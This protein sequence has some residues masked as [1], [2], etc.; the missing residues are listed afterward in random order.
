MFK[1]HSKRIVFY[2][3]LLLFFIC[4][5]PSISKAAPERRPVPHEQEKLA[6]DTTV[7][8]LGSL[9]G[10]SSDF[11]IIVWKADGSVRKSGCLETGDVAEID[12]SHGSLVYCCGITIL[13]TPSSSSAADGS[14]TENSSAISSGPPNTSSVPTPKPESIPAYSKWKPNTGSIFVI[15]NPVPVEKVWAALGFNGLDGA[16]SATVTSKDG[17]RRM[18]GPVCSGDTITVLNADG[19]AICTIPVAVRGDITRSGQATKAGCSILYGYLTGKNSLSPDLLAA[20]DMNRDGSVD[21]SDLLAMKQKINLE[22]SAP[23][24]P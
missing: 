12:N 22:S 18:S 16:V 23:S 3:I 15:E 21:T 2:C 4:M 24:A 14:G 9:F 10:I 17:V 7:E 8:E 13:G 20:A 5:V 1:R 19:Y 6:E 11:R